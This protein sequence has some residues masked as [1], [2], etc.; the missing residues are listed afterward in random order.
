[1]LGQDKISVM[2]IKHDIVGEN[3][4]FPKHAHF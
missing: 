1:M 2:K 4:L 3:N